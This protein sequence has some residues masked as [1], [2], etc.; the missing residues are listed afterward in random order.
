MWPHTRISRSRYV[1]RVAR[2]VYY[3]LMM[4]LGNMNGA[5]YDAWLEKPYQERYAEEEAYRAWCEEEG[6][7]PTED[8]TDAYREAM[9][10]REDDYYAELAE[11]RAQ[12][13]YFDR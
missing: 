11:A 8:H 4:N 3:Y 13:A 1:E 12:D 10:D 9:A 7:D 6:L 5:A 2:K